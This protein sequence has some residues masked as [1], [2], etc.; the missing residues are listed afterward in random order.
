[1]LHN[2]VEAGRGNV[3]K[4]RVQ[5]AAQFHPRH[6]LAISEPKLAAQVLGN[7]VDGFGRAPVLVDDADLIALSK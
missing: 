3:V 1:M 5:M 4:G 7:L 2:G 6:R